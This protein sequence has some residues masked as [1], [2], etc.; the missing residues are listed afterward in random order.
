MCK[1]NEVVIELPDNIATYREKRTVCIDSCIVDAIKHLWSKGYQTLGCCCGHGKNN[2]NIVIA[3]GYADVD[4]R[5]IRFE[6]LRVSAKT[7]DIFQWRLVKVEKFV[8]G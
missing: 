3:D 2:P 4:I 6:L 8:T 7:W 1:N 5:S